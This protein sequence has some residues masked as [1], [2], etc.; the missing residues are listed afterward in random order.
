MADGEP[1]TQKQFYEAM[2]ANGDT[3][4]TN[5]KEVITAINE[6]AI[7]TARLEE[8]VV[9]HYT[10]FDKRI[11]GNKTAIDKIRDRLWKIAGAGGISGALAAIVIRGFELFT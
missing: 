3:A 1:V 10:E 2:K 7:K 9:G 5:Q 6:Q 11:N 8:T 4:E